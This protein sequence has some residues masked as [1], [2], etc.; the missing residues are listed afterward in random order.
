MRRQR[1]C[2]CPVLFILV[3]TG[4]SEKTKDRNENRIEYGAVAG[5]AGLY[6]DAESLHEDENYILTSEPSVRIYAPGQRSDSIAHSGMYSLKLTKE[7]PYGFTINVDSVK[8]NEIIKA[9]FWC[10]GFE[11][12][13]VFC[14][15]GNIYYHKTDAVM[16][17]DSAGW[18]KIGLK[19]RA[20]GNLHN[21]ILRIFVW[22]YQ[23]TTGYIDDFSFERTPPVKRDIDPGMLLKIGIDSSGMDQLGEKRKEALSK[24][25]L[26]TEGGDYVKASFI[27][28]GDTLRGSLRLKGD[29]LDHLQGEKWSFR[30]KLK[31]VYSWKGMRTFSLQTPESR[32]F[33]NEWLLHL[34]LRKEDVLTTRYGFIN[35]ELNGQDMG[36]YAF[37]EHFDKLLIESNNRREG[38]IV[39]FSEET[40]WFT[41]RIS[42]TAGKPVLMPDFEESV[43]LPFKVNRTASTPGL[44]EQFEIAQNL[45]RMYK[46][47]GYSLPDMFDIEKL[48]RYLALI[49][50][51]QGYHGVTWHNQ[52]FYYNP[53]TCTLEPIAFDCYSV[54]PVKY[55]DSR[56]FLG[57]FDRPEDVISNRS[58]LVNQYFLDPVFRKFYFQYLEKYSDETYLKQFLKDA[59]PEIKKAEALLKEEFFYYNYSDSF[60]FK[61][62]SR[63]RKVLEKEIGR[64]IAED[65]SKGLNPVH[66]PVTYDLVRSPEA[67]P[68]YVRAYCQ[69]HQA[70]SGDKVKVV[71]S[72]TSDIELT[73]YVDSTGKRFLFPRPLKVKSINAGSHTRELEVPAGSR[74]LLYTS[75]LFE[76]IF[77]VEIF[78]WK[79]PENS[80][81]RIDLLKKNRTAFQEKYISGKKVTIPAGLH[82]FNE[83]IIIDKGFEVEIMA[84]AILNFTGGAF[85][86]SYSP[87]KALGEAGNAIRIFS[88]DGTSMGFIVLQARGKSVLNHVVFDR[89]KSLN[90]NGWN[91]TGAVTFYETEISM[92]DVQ[93]INNCSEDALNI[94]RSDFSLTNCLFDNIS[95]DAF[96]M[97][98]S[99]GTVEFSSFEDIK[100]DA[101]D[102]SGSTCTVRNCFVK[103]AKDKGL[104][105]GEGSVI[106]ADSVRIENVNIGFASKDNS[107]LEVRNSQ[108]TASRYGLMACK[109]KPEFAGAEIKADRLIL[110]DISVPFLIERGSELFLDDEFIKGTEEGV[111]E[112]FY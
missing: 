104:S 25:I 21:G 42:L 1:L 35:V 55:S 109:K 53:V 74:K 58:S 79:V 6:A 80:S 50:V 44:F 112:M 111:A 22:N 73:G 65:P 91:L 19:I 20:P 16:E 27:Y 82:E 12:F 85:L 37:E 29:W 13:L 88:G 54:E 31:S 14:D 34:L 77:S 18:K 61:N 62:A 23:G 69:M 103:N 48:A 70:N 97:D 28:M 92:T 51:T 81:P 52:R 46:E 59:E 26:D 105:V 78:K 49:D 87:V 38:P 100:N 89:L 84:G 8:R 32:Q 2:Y 45:M 94:V 86:L 83:P 68:L 101:L 107:K 24:G 71:N 56:V 76:D 41:T 5:I 33:I 98:F 106:M 99:D 39:K 10:Y 7:S 95:S 72:Y 67:P 64:L 102:F 66:K 4:C 93:F 36:V 43:I 110:R 40:F 15:S 57:Y 30:V 60:L 17:T 63:I 11:P 47:W 96:D 108:V 75:P 9:D 3:A 90:Y